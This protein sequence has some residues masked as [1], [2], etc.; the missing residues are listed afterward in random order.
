MLVTEIPRATKTWPDLDTKK[1]RLPLM[2]WANR[3]SLVPS[4]RSPPPPP[5][6]CKDD[7]V[8]GTESRSWPRWGEEITKPSPEEEAKDN[9]NELIPSVLPL[10][11]GSNTGAIAVPVF[12]VM[13]RIW[14]A[15]G[16]SADMPRF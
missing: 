7:R 1:R 8:P 16:M 14:W 6:G 15:G 4:W 11:L 9:D 13:D 3:I 10:L 12:P 5:S 2:F